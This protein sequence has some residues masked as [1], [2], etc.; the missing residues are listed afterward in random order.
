MAGPYLWLTLTA[1]ITALQSR[2]NAGAFWS[3][4]ELQVYLTEALR[5][6]NALCE[7]WKQDFVFSA[8]GSQWQNIGS[9]TGSPRLRSVTDWD[10]YTQMQL[11]LLEPP[12][13][14]STWNG[15]NQFSLQKLQYA[16]SNR[17]NEVIQAVACNMAQ[18]PPITAGVST[19]RYPLP[20]TTLELRRVRYL[21][22]ILQSNG[23][24]SSHSMTIAMDSTVGLAAGQLVTGPPISPGTSVAGVSAGT[25]TISLPVT[26]AFAATGLS[27]YQ[28]MTLTREDTQAFQDFSPGYLQDSGIPQSWTVVSNPPLSFDVD[29]SLILPGEMDAIVLTSGPAFAPPAMTLL[30]IPNDWAW[31]PMYGALADLL[32]EEAESTDRQRA[33]YCLKRYNDG[34]AMF[35]DSNWLIQATVNGIGCDTPSLGSKDWFLPEWEEVQGQIPCVVQDGIDFVNIAPG[36]PSSASLTLVQ[37]APILDSTGTYVQVTRDSWDS[38]LGYAHHLA[39][40]KCGGNDFAE[41]VPMLD[42]FLLK[43]QQDNKRVSTYGLYQDILFGAGKAQDVEEPR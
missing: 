11:M 7:E 1:A 36:A 3:P 28:P 9:M 35:K 5:M 22:L 27:F 41:T 30:G 24:A 38:V 23:A 18:L 6:R 39:A 8:T 16:L 33:T 13:G 42:E 20:D 12:S 2:L 17:R 31:L 37:N 4:A 10:I 15:T 14:G 25:I 43:C 19:R 40:F 26:A 34:L 21:A 32:G 29:K